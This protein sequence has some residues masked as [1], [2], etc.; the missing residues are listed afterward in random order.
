MTSR[1]PGSLTVVGIGIRAPEQT[2]FEASLRI[3]MAD[4]VYA[5][6]ANLLAE[7]WIRGLNENTQTLND[8]YSVNKERHTTYREMV[9]RILGAVRKNRQVCVVSYG[10]PGAFAYPFHEAI[11]RARAEGFSAEM[12]AG[13]SAEDCLFAEL[14]V[15]PAVAGCRSYE[16]TDFLVR[17][18]R[19]DTTSGL[20]LWQI[21]VIAELGFKE[22]NAA[23]NR[24]G[25]S[26]LTETLLEAYASDHEVVVYEA[27]RLPVCSS[28]IARIP[29]ERLPQ[30]AVGA[31]ATLYV[32]PMEQPEADEAM[33][34]RL[35]LVR[36]SGGSP[37]APLTG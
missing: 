29:L 21:G 15:D 6:V 18:R 37:A 35:G 31:M 23:W 20:I 27:A 36:S 26:V 14:G 32:P 25:L 13:I 5:L 16:A 19:M 11:R 33:L 12:L 22:Q 2:T 30:T 17:R 9:E 7:Y 8:L 28:K 4:E 1:R 24:N 34:R 10:H 3:K